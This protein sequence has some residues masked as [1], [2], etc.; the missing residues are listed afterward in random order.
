MQRFTRTYNIVGVYMCPVPYKL[1]YLFM[2]CDV[3]EE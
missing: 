2:Y 1:L 3:K